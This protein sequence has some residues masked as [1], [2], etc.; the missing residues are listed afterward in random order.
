M[1]DTTQ[2]DLPKAAQADN[3]AS[4]GASSLGS[5]DKKGPSV[6]T[7]QQ[8]VRTDDLVDAEPEPFK[9]Y[10]WLFRRH[11]YKVDD[12]AIATR[13][14]VYDE[15][16]GEM[17][18]PTPNYE[19]LHRFDP[20]ARWTYREEKVSV[21]ELTCHSCITHSRTRH[22]SKRLIGRSC[23]GP[24]S[25]SPPSIWIETTSPKR[26]Q[27]TFSQTLAWTRM[28]RPSFLSVYQPR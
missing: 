28:V 17:Y 20:S 26:I 7:H 24:L 15:P 4:T 25:A 11:L 1:A 8:D 10:N 12:D 21:T 27:T 9:L 2:P 13:R 3:R 16:L 5:D 23:F 22:L 18:W 6:E 14:S 19:N